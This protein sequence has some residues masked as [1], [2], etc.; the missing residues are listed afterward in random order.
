M[1]IGI[2]RNCNTENPLAQATEVDK[3]PLQLIKA[4]GDHSPLLEQGDHK[5]AIADSSLQGGVDESGQL[6]FRKRANFGRFG[7]AVLE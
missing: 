1:R 6:S 7:I 2:G 4:E 5:K 3:S